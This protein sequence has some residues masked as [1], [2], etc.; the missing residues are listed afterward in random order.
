MESN[1]YRPV[2]DKTN[3][4]EIDLGKQSANS[5]VQWKRALLIWVALPFVIAAILIVTGAHLGANGPDRWYT[6]LVI[7]FAD[8][9]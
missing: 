5:P 3:L 2:I 6:R 7:W 9:F 8:L 1:P 4:A